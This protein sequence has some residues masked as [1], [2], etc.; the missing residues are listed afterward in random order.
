MLGLPDAALGVAWPSLRDDFDQPLSALGVLLVVGTA[1]YLLAG[2][3]MGRAVA[4]LGLGGALAGATCLGTLALVTYAATP[5]WAGVVLASA[6]LGA[7]GGLLDAGLNAHLALSA[8]PRLANLLHAGFGV[9]ATT[10]PLLMTALL[11]GGGSWRTTYALLAV[12]EVVMAAAFWATRASW[13]GAVD[14]GCGGPLAASNAHRLVVPG[15][16]AAFFVYV[17]VEVSAGQW[18]YSLLTEGR[19]LSP[20]AAGTWVGAYWASL[21]VGR[22]AIALFGRSAS[23]A[24][25]LRGGV[26][27]AA[28]GAGL[29]WWAPVT[30]LGPLGLA[31]CGLGLAGV[32]PT[33]ITQLPTLVGGERA[34]AEAGRSVA[35]AGAGAGLLPLLVGLA[36]ESGGL[37]LLGPLLVAGLVGLFVLLALL[38]LPRVNA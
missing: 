10:G 8:S 13:S 2:L 27:V 15:V 30:S 20:S 6:L 18:S 7:G 14:A 28:A 25:L 31:L 22:V 23:P 5:T 19:G 11:V 16:L 12:V 17:G 4:R 36:L 3:A 29:L 24:G 35:A 9:G 38:P 34:A 37:E 1:A 21:T 33:L 26:V 32:F